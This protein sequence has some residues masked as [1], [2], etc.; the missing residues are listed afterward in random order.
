MPLLVACTSSARRGESL[1]G[2]SVFFRAYGLQSPVSGLMALM[3][4]SVHSTRARRA[5]KFNKYFGDFLTADGA[6][7][8]R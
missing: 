1:A 6:D 8:R 4:S 7:L 3:C 2:R 5:L